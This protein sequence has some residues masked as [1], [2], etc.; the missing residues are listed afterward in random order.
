MIIA[1]LLKYTHTAA[2]RVRATI[3]PGSLLVYCS[4]A[5]RATDPARASLP[6]PTPSFPPHPPSVFDIVYGGKLM[7]VVATG[8]M[9]SVMWKFFDEKLQKKL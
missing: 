1:L 3:L 6:T 7:H 5:V 4:T 2:A 8:I 9:F